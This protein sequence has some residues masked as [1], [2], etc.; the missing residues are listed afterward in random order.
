MIACHGGYSSSRASTPRLS[1]RQDQQFGSGGSGFHCELSVNV[2]RHTL[3]SSTAT[4]RSNHVS[5]H[6]LRTWREPG[7]LVQRRAARL[8]L[9]APTG[10]KRWTGAGI[11]TA[12]YRN[13]SRGSVDGHQRS[14]TGRSIERW[15]TQF[16]EKAKRLAPPKGA[17]CGA[18]REVRAG[19]ERR[20]AP[21]ATSPIRVGFGARAHWGAGSR[22]KGSSVPASIGDFRLYRSPVKSAHLPG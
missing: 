12:R 1:P 6:I 5:D 7:S 16:S 18:Q 19:A 13:G 14:A 8:G 22:S 3:C 15:R 11:M 17:G 4:A 9:R 10:R 2:T 21:T 20:P